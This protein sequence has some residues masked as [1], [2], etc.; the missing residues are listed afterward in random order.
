[1]SSKSTSPRSQVNFICSQY[2]LLV[3]EQD[4]GETAEEVGYVLRSSMTRGSKQTY[5]VA[6]SNFGAPGAPRIITLLFYSG[7]SGRVD[8]HFFWSFGNNMNK[9]NKRNKRNINT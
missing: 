6:N 3:N 7:V 1:M 2:I 8:Q 4:S 5:S 9:Q